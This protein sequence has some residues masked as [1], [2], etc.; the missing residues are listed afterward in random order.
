MVGRFA[1]VTFA[2]GPIEPELLPGIGARLH[3]L[4]AF[5]HDLLRTPDDPSVHLRDP[6]RWGAYV[7]APWCNRIA[8]TPV[9][10]DGELVALLPNFED[11]TAIHGQVSTAPWT[12]G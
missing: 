12:P 9:T 6:F 10:V 8:A 2:D 11:G 4:R 7:M 1:T 3:R 5:G